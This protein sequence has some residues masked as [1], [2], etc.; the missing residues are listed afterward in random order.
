MYPNIL[1]VI[2]ILLEPQISKEINQKKCALIIN[3]DF[4]VKLVNQF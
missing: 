2:S 4:S 1:K 3:D